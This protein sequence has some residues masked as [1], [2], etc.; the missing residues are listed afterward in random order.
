MHLTIARDTSRNF[1]LSSSIVFATY[2]VYNNRS[3]ATGT[4]MNFNQDVLPLV[5]RPL[6]ATT[7]LD[8]CPDLTTLIRSHPSTAIEHKALRQIVKTFFHRTTFPPVFIIVPALGTLI[9]LALAWPLVSIN[10]S[11]GKV[12]RKRPSE[13][14]STIPGCQIHVSF[15]FVSTSNSS[16]Q[17]PHVAYRGRSRFRFCPVKTIT[18]CP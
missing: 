13:N 3:M 9:D 8:V 11:W 18:P 2:M 1:E 4:P 6:I 16:S 7:A 5:P 17:F 14:K 15:P 12:H 10:C